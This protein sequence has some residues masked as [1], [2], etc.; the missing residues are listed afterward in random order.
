M[1]ISKFID[2]HV[3]KV[4]IFFSHAARKSLKALW[5]RGCFLQDL[6]KRQGRTSDIFMF[7][8]LLFCTDVCTLCSASLF[9]PI[10]VRRESLKVL[11]Q[12]K[13]M[14]DDWP[15]LVWRVYYY[16]VFFQI[17]KLWSDILTCIQSR[18]GGPYNSDL[19]SIMS[20][21]LVCYEALLF[22]PFEP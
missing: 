22:C 14:R 18:H 5:T 1:E 8:S 11:I 15:F 3:Q 4:V 16:V 12:V 9:L 10:M 6:F 19:L 13:I 20:P 2:L 17:E 7:N 21:L